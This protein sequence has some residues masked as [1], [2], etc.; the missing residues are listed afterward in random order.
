MWIVCFV[1]SIICLAVAGTLALR[2]HSS[3][4]K[5]K[6][7]P[8]HWLIGGVFVSS[9]LALMPVHWDHSVDDIFGLAQT[10]LLSVFNSLEMFAGGDHGWVSGGMENCTPALVGPYQL[11]FAVLVFSAPLLSVGFV[12]SLFANMTAYGRY[13][14]ARNA[15]KYIFSQL[16]EKSLVL[17]ED[18]RKEAPESCI[19]F[20]GISDDRE[21]QQIEWM[22]RVK[23]IGAICFKKPLLAVDFGKHARYSPISFFLISEDK[24]ENFRLAQQLIPQYRERVWDTYLYVFSNAPECEMMLATMDV[25]KM[26]IRRIDEAR[27]LVNWMLQ[28]KG[29]DFFD[30]AKEMADGTKHIGAVIVG[31][32]AHGTEMLKSLAWYCQMDGYSL[33]IDG[34][35]KDPLAKERLEAMVP[36][37]LDDA[38]NGVSVPGEAQYSIRIHPGVDVESATFAKEIKALKDT[39]YV[40]VA[41]GSDEKN[42]GTAVMLR[43]YF[44]RM[45]IKPVIQAMVFD[46]EKKAALEQIRNFKDQ[47]YDIQ[48]IGDLQTA[49]SQ[50]VILNRELEAAV[51]EL[52]LRYT[53]GD[54]AYLN[55]A[56]NNEY[57]YFS[58]AASAIHM[59]ARVHCD[60][61]GAGKKQQEL[62]E[63]ERY[64][65][66]CLEHRRWN[67]YMRSIGYVWSRGY[68][69]S[70]RNDLAKMH[71]NLVPFADLD[72]TTR[73]KDS[74][75]GTK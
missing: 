45:G 1:L 65:V 40:L 6:L 14:H 16:S 11:W 12:L 10:L 9:V 38:H 67:A 37:L 19:V 48:V 15:E 43:T 58:S 32:G 8:L 71:H 33:S 54:D 13:R 52:N 44:E 2:A 66:E 46:S 25:G 61:P 73:R 27:S 42:I 34:F 63:E 55:Y 57:S 47:S 21:N 39:T 23:D 60:I 49:Y 68:D 59:G 36:E 4:K 20:A 35:D 18:I 50:K 22:R 26:Q 74:L 5:R 70:S 62:T 3:V 69:V 30:N 75:V 24:E 64:A 17:A 53:G 31:M 72:E 28:G 29:T 51:T 7:K 56:L 41:L